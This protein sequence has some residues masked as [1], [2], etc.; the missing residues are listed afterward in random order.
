MKSAFSDIIGHETICDVLSRGLEN[1]R[2]AHAY[3]FVGPEGVG[4]TTVARALLRAFL[5]LQDGE[6]LEVHPDATLVRRQ[7]NESTGKLRTVV[8]VEQIRELRERFGMSSM[9]GERKA[10]FIEEADRMNT[11][12]AN[13]LLKTLE[14]PEGKACM[15]LR[16]PH[17]ESVL[18]T[19]S[20]RC[21]LIR[22][23]PV[24]RETI[25][26]AL[27]ARDCAEDDARRYAALSMG[28]PG[29]ALRMLEEGGLADTSK[30]AIDT[31]LEAVKGGVP[32]KL[33]AAKSLK[34]KKSQ[35]TRQALEPVFDVWERV[36]RDLMLMRVGCGDLAVYGS[37]SSDLKKI[38]NSYSAS[39]WQDALRSV[40]EVRRALA[41]N[42]NAQ[43]ALEKVL[44]TI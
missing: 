20:S 39:H 36:L 24:E 10:A 8:R 18:P 30:Q 2:L 14:E 13:A 1:G 6:T 25:A 44:L 19:I 17:K 43:L 16:A 28:R 32:E 15:I 12:G 37:V 31:L 42:V 34:P 5:K 26:K 9:R 35:G 4:R 21:Q 7:E 38:S 33:Q 29:L 11:S 22:F 3:L 27:I 23:H 40:G 41:R